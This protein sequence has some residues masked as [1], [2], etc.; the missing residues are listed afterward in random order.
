MWFVGEKNFT[1][2]VQFQ[3]HV[4]CVWVFFYSKGVIIKNWVPDG[5]TVN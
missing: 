4:Y 5:A 1:K 2:E 3:G